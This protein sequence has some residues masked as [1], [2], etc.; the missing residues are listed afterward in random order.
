VWHLDEPVSDSSIIPNF[1]ISRFAA[2]S[3]KVCLSGLGGDE[4]FGGYARYLDQGAGRIRGVF[5]KAPMLSGWMA[6]AING[7]RPAWS[8]ELRQ[9]SGPQWSWMGYANKIQIFNT[10]RLS[11]VGFCAK[12]RFEDTL[13]DLWKR[14]P[15][16]DPVTQR[17]F[18]DQHT[19]LPD[20]ILAL[21]DRM[22]MA[23]SLEVRVPFM[24]YRLV[25]FS[26]TVGSALK[27]DRSD[28]KILLKHSLGDRVPPELLTRPKWGF[29]T[30]LRKWVTSPGISALI[31][32]LPNGSAV[33]SGL[34]PRSKVM[35]FVIDPESIGRFP[36]GAWALLVLET[37]LRVRSRTTAPTETLDELLQQKI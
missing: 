17:Q 11:S 5:G 29:D 36:R 25:R 34:F 19:Y 22:S 37:W 13:Q 15:G 28:Y 18:I 4:L 27:Q 1:L 8:S 2:E 21:T 16:D 33:R 30:P 32:T 20:Q 6:S 26:Q 35:N 24:D 31:R 14:F 12:G 10:Q 3:V 7:W 23:N 9:A